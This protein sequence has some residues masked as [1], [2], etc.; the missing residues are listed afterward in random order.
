M[1]TSEVT[2]PEP[3]WAYD[4]TGRE[5]TPWWMRLGAGLLVAIVLGVSLAAVW[6]VS[7][8]I[9][10]PGPITNVLGTVD[11]GEHKGDPVLKPSGDTYYPAQGAL[12]FTTV[13]EIGTPTAKPSAL[14]VFKGWLDSTLAVVPMGELYPEGVPQQQVD[15]ENVA[16]MD[17]SQQVATAVAERAAGFPV[18]P[19]IV[20][21]AFPENAPNKDVLKVG[22]EFVKIGDTSVSTLAELTAAI[23]SH[24]A[25]QP[26]SAVVARGGARVPVTLKTAAKDGRTT[27]GVLLGLTYDF[28]VKVAVNVGNVSGPSAGLMLSLGI[29]DVLTPKDLTGDNQIAGTGTMSDDGTV[30]P[31]GGIAQ[32]LVG[33]RIGGARY[34]LAPKDN[35]DEVVGHIPDGLTVFAVSTFD[36]AKNAVEAIANKST[37]SLPTCAGTPPA[38]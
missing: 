19:R 8:A 33:A 18:T 4:G 26:L 2:T 24:P 23:R 11:G 16:L 37:Q 28:R 30:G 34:F 31:I 7:Y 36:E 13:R 1:T 9:L 27:V 22:D 25:G 20:I 32:K 29:Y 17:S 15:D 14:E 21:Q 3:E 5:R 12:F 35:C 38:T 6:P 10:E